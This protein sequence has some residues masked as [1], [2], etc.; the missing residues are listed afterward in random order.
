MNTGP[1][2]PG[3]KTHGDDGHAKHSDVRLFF[4][5][6]FEILKISGGREVEHALAPFADGW[7]RSQVFSGEVGLDDHHY[8]FIYL[9][10]W[11]GYIWLSIYFF[12]STLHNG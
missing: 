5:M 6:V 2:N 10:I 4:W 3:E 7:Q 1:C 12:W 8:L 11:C 9:S